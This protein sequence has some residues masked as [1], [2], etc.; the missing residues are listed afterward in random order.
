[1]SFP[2]DFL[3]GGAIAANQAEGA[4]LEGN[5]GLSIA[6]VLPVGNR[7]ITPK[8][9]IDQ[10]QYY[11]SHEAIDFYHTYEKDIEMLSKLG[12]KCFRTSIAWSRI[13]PRGDEEMPNEEGLLY[14]DRLIDCLIKYN[15]EPVITLSHFETPLT[16]VKEYNGWTNRKLITFFE[17]YCKVVFERYK[18]KVKYWMTFNEINHA[19]TLPFLAAGI[20]VDEKNEQQKLQD[21]YQ[22]SHHMLVASA[23]VVSLGHT[24]NPNF[25]IGCMLSLSPTYS[26]TTK[27]EDVFATFQL[28]R[29]FLF[30]SDVQMRGAYPSYFHRIVKENHLHI[31]MC[32]DDMDI[33]KNGKCDYLGFSYY[34]S[35]L[36]EANMK[37][38]GNTGGL[39]GKKNPY[40]KE[41]KWGW[42][43]DAIGLR[44]VCNEL[45]DRYQKPLFIVENGLGAKD[46]LTSDNAY[47]DIER[48]QYLHDHIEQLHEAIKDGCPIIGYTW[49]GPL[50][51][52]SA[53]SGEMEKRYGF[54]HVDKD[55]KGSGTLKRTYKKSFNYYKKIIQTNGEDIEIE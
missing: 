16:L 2:K 24:I 31:E 52:V 4:Y 13:F 32:D 41:T 27:P 28:R 51:I 33:L 48:I 42:P 19:H 22:A 11:P 21:I 25:Q 46:E 8:L 43:I 37:I 18:D 10:T 23:K 49:W 36:H 35:S 50:D 53:G 17:R 54:I 12:L 5:K 26:A 7:A 44:Y 6:D 47:E 9:E 40:L 20:V 55:N 45:S 30:Y 1:M 15:M 38:L 29:R 39:L 3:W 34:R 14:Y